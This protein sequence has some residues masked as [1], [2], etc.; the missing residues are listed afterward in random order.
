MDDSDTNNN[1]QYTTLSQKQN[2]NNYRTKYQ[3]TQV[4]TIP[5]V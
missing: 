1:N 5:R 2:K 3:T 4:P